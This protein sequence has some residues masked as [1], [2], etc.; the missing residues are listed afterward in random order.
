VEFTWPVMLWG[1]VLLPASVAWYVLGARRIRRTTAQR[2]AEAPLF[3]QIA[4]R[5]PAVR[6][7]ISMALYFAAL[8]LL[9]G[10]AA[11]P[12]MAVPLPVNRA[13]VIL[14]IDTS[15]SM[16]APD[17]QP[18][19]L[20]AAR[21]AA[22]GFLDV[23][24]A[25][26]RVGLVTFSTYATLMV[27][28][29][30]DRSA[31]REGLASLKTQEATAIGDGIAVSLRALPGRA[32]SVPGGSPGAGGS[33]SGQGPSSPSPFGQ[34]P[35]GQ[36]PFTAPVPPVTGAQPD[37]KDLPPAAIILLTDG[38]QNAGTADP[39]RMAALAK[40]LKVKIYTIGLGTPG[41][42][43][44]NYQG[45]MVLVP[46]DPTLLQQIASITDGKFFM[47]PTAGD[48]K[49]IYRE[50]GRTI[51]WE[52]RK[53]EVSALFVAGAGVLMLGGGALSLFW[54]GRLP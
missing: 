43:V 7:H 20:D 5:L 19:R 44:F 39:I 16:A 36:T 40:Q 10:A 2:F 41:G 3:S 47:S 18:T 45:Q 6:R 29:T 38:G 9:L 11:R 12:V 34:P 27:P 22:S 14:A 23:F 32:A 21:Q 30:D 1:L 33:P 51:G 52:K 31:V 54:M 42:G 50:L 25:G 48:L 26:P 53:T 24:P 17:L 49:Q 8:A 15:G 37:A 28:P 46:F 4:V 13:T 35:A